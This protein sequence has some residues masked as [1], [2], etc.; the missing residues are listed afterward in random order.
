MENHICPFLGFIDDPRKRATYPDGA[1]ACHNI[2][3]PVLLDIDYQRSTCLQ[4]AHKKCPGYVHGWKDNVPRSIRRRKHIIPPILLEGLAWLLVAAPFIVLLWMGLTGRLAFAANFTRSSTI[5]TPTSR[6]IFTRT[7]TVTLT[8]TETS[9][10]TVTNTHAILLTETLTPTRKPGTPTPTQTRQNLDRPMVSVSYRTNCRKGPGVQYEYIG[11]LLVGEQAEVVG[12]SWNGRYWVIKNPSQPG[13]C[14][15]W[16]G[17]A[18][19]TGDT[20]GLPRLFPPPRPTPTPTPT[21]IS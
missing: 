6:I 8:P 17:Y 18:N 13:E 15:L 10:P 7:P 19:V 14:W 12:V 1:N 11:A 3:Q 21:P 4:A 2:K 9:T 5:S 20:S 16:G